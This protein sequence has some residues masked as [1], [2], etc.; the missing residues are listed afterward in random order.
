MLLLEGMKTYY[1][2]KLLF[3]IPKY[4]VLFGIALVLIGF[5]CL[6]SNAGET[7]RVAILPLLI[8]A[9]ER[10]EYLRGGVEDMLTSRLTWEDKVVVLDRSQVQKVTEKITGSIEEPRARQI[11]K[12]LGVEVVLWGS[13]SVIGSNVSL[14]L[15]LVEIVRQQPVKKFFAQAKG[16]D[17]VILR[18]NEISDNINE[19][20]FSRARTTPAPVVSVG[21]QPSGSP[22]TP[23]VESASEKSKLSLKGFIINP[24]S[25]QIIMNAGGFDM[26]GVWRSTIL[27]FALVDMAFG[28]LDGDGKIET[29]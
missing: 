11:G 26:S 29:V 24:L 27:P 21:V 4:L 12:Q 16:M 28:D 7:K 18:I 8:N 20:V 6:P 17:E 14:D 1:K 19:K 5:F 22:G 9:P 2:N 13:I 10:M 15:N 25:P 23:S 3:P